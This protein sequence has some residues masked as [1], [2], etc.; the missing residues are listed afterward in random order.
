M[1]KEQ[2]RK[3]SIKTIQNFDKYTGNLKKVKKFIKKYPKLKDLLN[4]NYD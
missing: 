3:F 2:V 1:T 4:I